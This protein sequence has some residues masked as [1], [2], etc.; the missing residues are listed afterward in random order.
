MIIPVLVL[1]AI[2]KPPQLAEHDMCRL[3]Y[4]LLLAYYGMAMGFEFVDIS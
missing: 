1:G 3:R 4:A 2:T